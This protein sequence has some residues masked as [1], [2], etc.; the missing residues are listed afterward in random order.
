MGLFAL[1]AITTG[2]NRVPDHRVSVNSVVSTY[3]RTLAKA[4]FTPARA[5]NKPQVAL[6][7]LCEDACRNW[8]Q[9]QFRE[10]KGLRHLTPSQRASTEELL[11]RQR[12]LNQASCEDLCVGARDRERAFCLRDATNLQGIRACCQG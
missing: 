8:V 10:P 12:V 2:C 3:G 7:P 5:P 11:E 4:G 1:T 9:V 6:E